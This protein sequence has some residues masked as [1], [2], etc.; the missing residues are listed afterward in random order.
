MALLTVGQLKQVLNDHYSDD[1][2]IVVTWWS[3]DDVSNAWADIFYDDDGGEMTSEE[4]D[5]VWNAISVD[6]D[7][8]LDDFISGA[9]EYLFE[10]V[11]RE[12]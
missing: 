5:D 8:N 4:L 11:N 6:F 7:N 9:N 2:T 12:A 10:L 1:S 3:K